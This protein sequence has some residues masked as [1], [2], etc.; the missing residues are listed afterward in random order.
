MGAVILFGVFLSIQI[1]DILLELRVLR[2]YEKKKIEFR[3]TST[4]NGFYI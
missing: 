2:W 4:W 3:R 1:I